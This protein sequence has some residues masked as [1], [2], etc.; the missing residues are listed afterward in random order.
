MGNTIF[1]IILCYNCKLNEFLIFKTV[2]F[3]DYNGKFCKRGKYPLLKA[4]NEAI[5]DATCSTKTTTT[6]EPSTTVLS[7]TQ[8]IA[9]ST[10]PVSTT[11]TTTSTTTTST[12]VT[13]TTTKATTR[14]KEKTN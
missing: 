1:S 3:D 2:D 10:R 9:S 7:S 6:T 14:L 11:T 4:L 12:K 13:T 5:V 8:T